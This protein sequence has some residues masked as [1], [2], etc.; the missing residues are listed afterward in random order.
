[1]N[2][3]IIFCL[4]PLLGAGWRVPGLIPKSYQMQEMLEIFVGQLHSERTGLTFD[5]YTLNWCQNLHGVGY[6]K[7]HYGT[8]LT[9]S[10]THETSYQYK[11]GVERNLIACMKTL[12]HGEK[13]Q[14]SFF[15]TV[16]NANYKRSGFLNLMHFAVDFAVS[17][18][19]TLKT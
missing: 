11:F 1:M 8:T 14:F 5:F 6:K 15:K 3:C 18:L 7:E 17:H 12:T 16:K 4:V 2:K 19:F 13:E 10:P 9:G